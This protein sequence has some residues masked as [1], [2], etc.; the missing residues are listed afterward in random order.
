MG[1]HIKLFEEYLQTLTLNEG[2]IQVFGPGNPFKPMGKVEIDGVN[3][4]SNGLQWPKFYEAAQ[5]WLDQKYAVSLVTAEFIQNS[6][7]LGF[8]KKT[9]NPKYQSEVN[10]TWGDK[11]LPKFMDEHPD[12]DESDFDLVKIDPELKNRDGVY[13][14]DKDG[15]EFCIHASRILDV[16]LGSSVRDEVYSGTFYMIDNMRARISNYQNGIVTVSFKAGS[17]DPNDIREYTLQEWRNK[18]FPSLDEN[19][20]EEME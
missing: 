14:Q 3:Y 17:K 8:D 12:Y 4:G 7:T 16:Q 2:S 10:G 11:S 19:L 6:D 13:I 1:K 18:N 15:N 5:K 9:T 20:Q